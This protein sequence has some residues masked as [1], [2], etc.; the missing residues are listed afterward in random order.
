[1]KKPSD[2]TLLYRIAKYYYMERRTQQEIADIENI[3]RSQ[4]SRL[5][6]RAMDEGIVSYKV[7]LPIEMDV[8]SMHSELEE[9]LNL[10]R[11]ILIPSQY[12]GKGVFQDEEQNRNLA[13]GAADYLNDL[14]IDSKV[15]GVG[16]GRTMY[17]TS[18]YLHYK[19]MSKDVTVVPLVGASGDRNP[20][21]QINTIVDRFSEHI[22]AERI[23]VNSLALSQSKYQRSPYEESMLQSLIEYWEMLDSAVIGIGAPPS[24]SKT[25]IYEFSEDY[26]KTIKSSRAIGDILSQ[27]YYKNGKLLELPEEYQLLAYDIERLKALPNVIAIAAG[28]RKVDSI[29]TAAK[30]GII[31][32][33]ITDYDTAKE[34]LEKAQNN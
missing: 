18:Q 16:W 1:M 20:N 31:K 32:T 21:L 23:Y 13:V 4:I 11:V 9:L 2:L 24:V 10:K 29:I 7:E 22:N 5:L 28:N 33:L 17:L 6:A 12:N 27:F 26:V 3:S 25:M 30:M 19:H 8:C 34:I 14:L 15:I